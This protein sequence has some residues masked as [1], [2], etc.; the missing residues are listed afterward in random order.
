[1]SKNCL[2]LSQFLCCNQKVHTM[3]SRS[4][5]IYEIL[6]VSLNIFRTSHNLSKNRLYLFKEREFVIFAY[7]HY[8]PVGHITVNEYEGTETY[9]VQT[10]KIEGVA[11][12]AKNTTDFSVTRNVPQSLAF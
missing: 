12:G 4:S 1:M 3:E 6:C 7:M 8:L 2:H 9:D 10:D 11:T 5:S